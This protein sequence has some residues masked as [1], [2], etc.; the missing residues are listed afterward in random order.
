M[1]VLGW[2]QRYNYLFLCL[3]MA[4]FSAGC[5]KRGKAVHART[6]SSIDYRE[7][8]ALHSEIPDSMLGFVVDSVTHDKDDQQI[9]EIVY[10][11][12]KD[13]VIVQSDVRQSYAADMELLGWKQIGEF[14][15]ETIQLLFE[16]PRSKVLC[17]VYIEKNGTIRVTLLQ[18]IVS[19]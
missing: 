1:N 6:V 3:V 4:L 9:I 19:S 14:S 2:L 15:G 5:K 16:R 10:R 7:V 11:P 12:S 18:K 17:S 8:I 13:T